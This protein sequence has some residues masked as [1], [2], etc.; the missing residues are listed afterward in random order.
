M[1]RPSSLA[2][3]TA[4][5]AG[6]VEAAAAVG[7]Q[8]RNP[9]DLDDAAGGAGAGRRDWFA[10]V[11]ADQEMEVVAQ[12]NWRTTESST[13]VSGSQPVVRVATW[14]MVRGWRPP[15][16]GRCHEG[17]SVEIRLLGPVEVV[18]DAGAVVAL[19]SARQR[20][21]VAGLCVRAG[22]VVAADT[23][24]ELLWGDALPADPAAA[25]QSQMSRLR[26][27]LGPAAAIATVPGGYRFANPGIVDVVRFRRLLE[28]ARRGADGVA[29]EEALALWRGRP[30]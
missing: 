18:D 13:G 19:A 29:V 17:G 24:V 28:R 20:L 21:L 8:G 7:G 30:L 6:P 12:A 16:S 1:P 22:D 11:V 23:L 25:L 27:R 9:V 2:R 5:R 15:L 26:R 4:G 10:L 3:R 14:S